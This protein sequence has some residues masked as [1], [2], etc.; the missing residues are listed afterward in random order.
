M[1]KYR[2]SLFVFL[3]ISVFGFSQTDIKKLIDSLSNKEIVYQPATI[4]AF[5]K[6]KMLSTQID[7][8]QNTIDNVNLIV[9]YYKAKTIERG[10]EP[11]PLLLWAFKTSKI[12]NYRE[13]KVNVLM[14][15]GHAYRALLNIKSVD[16]Y[17][18]ALKIYKEDNNQLG[19]TRVKT[20][21]ALSY[22][23][24]HEYHK[25]IELFLESIEI[26][27][28][29][30]EYR[31]IIVNLHN[32][33]DTYLHASDTLK[34]IEYFQKSSVLEKK[35]P[36]IGI[37]SMNN[38]FLGEIFLKQG[39]IIQAENYFKESNKAVDNGGYLYLKGYNSIG[40][41]K[42]EELRGNHDKAYNYYIE[43]F[44]LKYNGGSEKIV[45]I[46]STRM[47]NILIKNEK[48]D[49]ALYLLNSIEKNLIKDTQNEVLHDKVEK[50]KQ[51]TLKHFQDR[52][53]AQ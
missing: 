38:Y 26:L 40:L 23:S 27:K 3:L 5:N 15:L 17:K 44:K 51:H 53:A 42:I 19:I 39:D 16:F 52:V 6:A 45:F 10:E 46:L 29:S 48:Y 43:S 31:S 24:T 25:S 49:D 12:L 14:E 8:T 37:R 7:T 13:G 32:L 11:F 35:H 36:D 50:Q 34:A 20:G 22:Y 30:N 4:D 2:V 1:N 18:E 28:K 33:G 41:G 21:I 47:A 9:D